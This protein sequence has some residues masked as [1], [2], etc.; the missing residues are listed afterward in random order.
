M[1]N[2]LGRVGEER[3]VRRQGDLK[4]ERALWLTGLVT[5]TSA[6]CP[7]RWCKPP[8]PDR[9]MGLEQDCAVGGSST[10]DGTLGVRFLRLLILVLRGL[11]AHVNRMCCVCGVVRVGYCSGLQ[12]VMIVDW[13]LGEK[14]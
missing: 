6:Q 4:M 2:G 8:Y 13:E 7:W 11:W 9:T 5:T 3:M 10:A 14:K 12:W 1:C